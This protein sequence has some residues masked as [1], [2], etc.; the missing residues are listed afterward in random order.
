ML[1]DTVKGPFL[2][3]DLAPDSKISDNDCPGQAGA[4]AGKHRRSVGNVES[5]RNNDNHPT[6]QNVP[7]P[8]PPPHGRLTTTERMVTHGNDRDDR[9]RL[10]S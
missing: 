3:P 10:V 6:R 2:F 1:I 8:P 9:T 7:R 4:K 5:D